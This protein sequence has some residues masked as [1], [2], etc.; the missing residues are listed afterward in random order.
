MS[1]QPD[2]PD[3]HALDRMGL[4]AFDAVA[5]PDQWDDI[6]RRADGAELGSSSSA[7]SRRS[8]ATWFMAAAAV[9]LVAVAAVAVS[10][11]SGNDSA[12]TP[13]TT[14]D[15]TMPPPD[16][17]VSLPVVSPTEPPES[18]IADDLVELSD[19][20]GMPAG[21]A[22]E[23]L[24]AVGLRFQLVEVVDETAGH[25]VVLGWSVLGDVDAAPGSLVPTGSVVE[26]TVA[27]SPETA[28]PPPDTVPDNVPD[29]VDGEVVAAW[30][31]DCVER[32][33]GAATLGSI[34]Q[35]LTQ[36][37][38]VGAEPTLD[39]G[40]PTIETRNGSESPLLSPVVVPGGV[41]LTLYGQSLDGTDAITVEVVDLDGAVRWRRCLEGVGWP[42]ALVPAGR[43]LWLAA[44]DGEAL[45]L[46][47]DLS[48]GADFSPPFS[49]G[50]R[51]IDGILGDRVLVG[52][53]WDAG[54]IDADSRLG[55]IDLDGFT[56]TDIPYP[57]V[58]IG[59]PSDR[60]RYE[61]IEGDGALLVAA[62]PI[63]G[64]LPETVWTGEA[65]SSDP[66]DLRSLP[67]T[68]RIPYGEDS[69]LEL[70]DGAGDVVWSEPGFHHISR[71]GFAS[72]VSGSVALV[73][74]CLTWTDGAGC[75]WLDENTPPDE[76]LVAFDLETGERL[77]S[78]PGG[79][80]F[81][82]LDGN[83]GIVTADVG[84][85]LIDLRTG[86]R[87]DDVAVAAWPQDDIFFNECCGAGD[88]IWTRLDG[89]V[90]FEATGDRLRVW[91]PPEAST[92]TITTDAFS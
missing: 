50:D 63:D 79:Q 87:V 19:W 59:T 15:A 23:D 44:G 32:T 83:R 49:T 58:A 80:A 41:A 10:V 71:E 36:F 8:P 16:T 45:L 65:W 39:L 91:L 51:T 82:A 1:D 78:R 73:M 34:D 77:W 30:N 70:L 88:Y 25:D 55:V 90:L 81:A 74:E 42:R 46:P 11:R 89:G 56:A 92:P 4:D 61:L 24:Q 12:P 22:I 6:T 18:T 72:A 9:A 14:P 86:E 75:Q 64:S 48:T 20:T 52:V 67:P 29:M 13:A 2:R 33:S 62:T 60:V 76:Q 57:D 21:L 27:V 68:L 38:T 54:V 31:P 3:E 5:V 7:S 84:W 43:Q 66:D 37:T 35:A 28:A 26:L 53:P 40:V 69:V 85:E 17:T 47:F